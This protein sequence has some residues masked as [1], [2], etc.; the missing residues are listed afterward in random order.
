MTTETFVTQSAA[1]RHIEDL[2]SKHG[3]KAGRNLI[4]LLADQ[5]RGR[6]ANPI[7]FVTVS[8]RVLYKL[9]DLEAWALAEIER[10]KATHAGVFEVEGTTEL[11]R[12]AKLVVEVGKA[13]T[14]H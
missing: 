9:D 10:E 5:R 14:L 8:K 2:F 7:P 3:V 4:Y 12:F 6:L 13:R 1:I 11:E